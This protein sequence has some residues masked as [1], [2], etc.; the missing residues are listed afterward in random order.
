MLKPS[1]ITLALLF[2]AAPAFAEEE[3]TMHQVYLAAEAGKFNEA[4]SRWTRCCM[5][6]PTQRQGAFC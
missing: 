5:T 6:I 1:I 3:P 2:L 4:Q